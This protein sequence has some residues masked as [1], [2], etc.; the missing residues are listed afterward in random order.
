MFSIREGFL[1]PLFGVRAGEENCSDFDR[2]AFTSHVLGGAAMR[3][4]KGMMHTILP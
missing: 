4:E 1:S 2:R 3:N